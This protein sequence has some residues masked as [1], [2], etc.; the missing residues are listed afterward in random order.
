MFKKSPE[1]QADKDREHFLRTPVGQAQIAFERGDALFQY[2]HD[3]ESQKGYS[4]G[5]RTTRKTSDPSEILNAVA[6]EGWELVAASFVFREQGGCATKTI[7]STE[8][9]SVK[10]TTVGYYVFRRAAARSVE[11]AAA[12]L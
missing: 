12:A 9:A 2:S 7:L 8:S 6:A 3:V 10:G 1:Q 5:V 4:T 11:S